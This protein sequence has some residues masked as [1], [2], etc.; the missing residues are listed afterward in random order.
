MRTAVI[1]LVGLVLSAPAAGAFDL[2]LSVGLDFD[3]ELDLGDVAAESETGYSL[4]LELVFDLPLLEL[5]GGLE[6][7]FE[8]DDESGVGSVDYTHLYAVARMGLIGP[9]YAVGRVGWSDVSASDLVEGDLGDGES[10]SVGAGVGLLDKLKL[11]VLLNNFSA[12][13]DL[14]DFDYETYSARVIYIF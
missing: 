4:G 3:G 9:L 11:E 13:G 6:Y 5:G 1:L 10:W 2:G 8:R 14:G 12:D 7:G